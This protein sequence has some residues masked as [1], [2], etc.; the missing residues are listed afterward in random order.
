MDIIR[1]L[2]LLLVLL[3]GLGACNTMDGVGEDV[4]SASDEVD[5]EL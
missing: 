1:K 3:M 5:E 4:E 2:T